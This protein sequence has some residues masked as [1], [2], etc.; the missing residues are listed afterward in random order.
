[1]D[2]TNTN[3]TSDIQRSLA[4]PTVPFAVVEEVLRHMGS[5]SRALRLLTAEYA[6][7]HF[8]A[9]ALIKSQLAGRPVSRPWQFI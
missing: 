4:N 6:M 7:D 1:M 5:V 3:V 9:L 2:I 8:S